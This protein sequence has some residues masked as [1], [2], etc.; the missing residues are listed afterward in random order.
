MQKSAWHQ[1][2]P[3]T[4]KV[5]GTIIK[6]WLA[7]GLLAAGCAGPRAP[8]AP[9]A[10][11]PEAFS[12]SG[13]S[14][15][16]PDWWRAFGDPVLAGLIEA[17]QRDNPGLAATWERLRQAR[18]AAERDGA[19]ARPTLEG[20]AGAERQARRAPA[21]PGGD[22]A[23]AYATEFSLGL[24]AGYEVDLWGRIRAVR[25]AAA[26]EAKAAAEEFRT[27]AI[28]LA[29]ETAAL[30]FQWIEQ[31]G[32]LDLLE[33][34]LTLNTNIL[35]LVTRRFQSGQAA[36]NDVLQ[37]RQLIESLRGEKAA[38]AARAESLRH[39]LTILIGQPPG[40]EL[41]PPPAAL[42]DPPPLPAAGLPIE[43][44]QH[45]PD[46]RRMQTLVQAADRRAAAAFA[47][48]F[49]RLTL[50]AQAATTAPKASDLF[51]AGL[52]NLAAGLLAPLTDGGARRAE[53]ERARAA[54]AEQWQRYRETALRA[55]AEVE[56]ALLRERRQVELLDSLDR[57][58]AFSE[59]I[60][61]QTRDR[62]LNGAADYLRVL[63]ALLTRQRLQRAQLEARRQRL[64][65][66][67][68]L[69]R[70]LGAG[71]S[72]EA[73]AANGWKP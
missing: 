30:W 29:A 52:A 22:P 59:Q 16:A 57:Q 1:K 7:A 62:Y 64:G 14:P 55:L 8:E 36:A 41:P 48:R 70:A 65:Y 17:A 67:V 58:L 40:A 45:R 49:P 10:R 2:A 50:T 35:D 26:L 53:T 54:R 31:R 38:A 23:T 20:R 21:T 69:Y 61:A 47:Q 39:Q 56:T 3:G 71:W 24:A 12:P 13:E 60:V 44:L 66:R 11:L 25:D 18:A 42:P 27:A 51:D 34:Q 15:A 28:S 73:A 63:D 32:Q 6:T 33:G 43:L 37:Q 72:P 4:K 46:V 5:P 68:D 9:V 19:G